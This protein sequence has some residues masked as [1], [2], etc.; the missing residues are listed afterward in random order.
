MTT[1]KE[2]GKEE[3]TK[4]DKK[5]NSGGGDG[6]GDQSHTHKAKWNY[7]HSDGLIYAREENII[8]E[9]ERPRKI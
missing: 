3:K 4:L 7:K 9:S 5:R 2:E 8:P 6:D 1:K